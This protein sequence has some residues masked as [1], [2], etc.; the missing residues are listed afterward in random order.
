M[1][2]L[3]TAALAADL[4]PAWAAW[5]EGEF[6]TAR[7]LAD[8]ALAANPDDLAARFVLGAVLFDHE[9]DL[10]RAAV[11][12]ESVIRAYDWSGDPSDEA[13]WMPHAMALSYR[14]RVAAAMD[15]REDQLRWLDRHDDG[16]EPHESASRAW[17]LMK[18]NRVD[19]ARAIIDEVLASDD[20]GDRS[21]VETALCAVEGELGNRRAFDEACT[22]ALEAAAAR[23]WDLAVVS[24]N[25]AGAAE[26]MLR[27]GDAEA[28]ARRG[29]SSSAE[30]ISNPWQRIVAATLREG[31]G[32]AA[33]EAVEQMQAWRLHQLPSL[34]DQARASL[35]TSF[36]VVLWTAGHAEKA[37]ELMDRA[38]QMPDRAGYSSG[39]QDRDRVTSLLLRLQMRADA[40]ERRNEGVIHEA[41]YLRWWTRGVTVV[42]SW[43]DAWDAASVRNLLLAGGELDRLFRVYDAHGLGG[44]DPWYAGAL[45]PVLGTSVAGAAIEAVDEDDPPGLLAYRSAFL[46]ELAWRGGG[47]ALSRID[48]ALEGLPPQ[49]VLLR[50]RLEAMAAD[51]GREESWERALRLD[52]G[53]I[54]R[55][56]LALPVR[57]EVQG[58]ADAQE[59]ADALYRSPRLW[60]TSDGL[61]VVVEDRRVC[62]FGRTGARLGCGQGADIPTTLEAFH[63]NALSLPMQ[64][65]RAAIDRLDGVAALSSERASKQVGDALERLIHEAEPP[66][67][68]KKP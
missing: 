65:D 14:A 25:A 7:R 66:P 39:T 4:G 5:D 20:E 59:M 22:I 44:V 24:Y 56:G 31:R 60:P 62:L 1:I 49:E 35:D 47:D 30:D 33:V 68:P 54:R 67:K 3:L 21:V 46:G 9:G 57:V 45:I 23:G 32:P 63:L 16:Y 27:L 12:L 64:L 42:E 37:V 43:A 2:W 13:Q 18:L 34:R 26:A 41:W 29:L 15:D 28:I 48:E 10:P 51:L 53:V 38:L 55:L 11:N 8:E 19:E 17:A 52:P 40:R 50:A 36:A 58:G 61:A 6:T